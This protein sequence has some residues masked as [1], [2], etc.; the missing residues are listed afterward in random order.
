[1]DIA[2]FINDF[3]TATDGGF[4]PCIAVRGEKGYNLTD[5]NWGTDKELA[6]KCADK[7]NEA[8]GLSNDD[9]M[10]IICSTMRK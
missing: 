5:W 1:M 6:E 3:A 8:L 9:V 7:K 4:I 2:Y 10:E